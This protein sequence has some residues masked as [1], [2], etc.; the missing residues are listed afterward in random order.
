M[1]QIAACAE[2]VKRYGPDP[3]WATPAPIWSTPRW[4]R[5]ARPNTGSIINAAILEILISVRSPT[6][7]TAAKWFRYGQSCD[8]GDLIRTLLRAKLSANPLVDS[9]GRRGTQSQPWQ[10]VAY[11]QVADKIKVH[12]VATPGNFNPLCLKE[13]QTPGNIDD[14]VHFA[15]AVAPEEQT[16]WASKRPLD[17]MDCCSDDT[18]KSG[19]SRDLIPHIDRGIR[20]DLRYAHKCRPTMCLSNTKTRPENRDMTPL[21]EPDWRSR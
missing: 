16:L 8:R 19:N 21:P 10:F 12:R 14:E 3:H 13:L 17:P 9:C 4:A 6:A 7:Q 15:C 20:V 5:L 2:H 11:L 18:R 1:V